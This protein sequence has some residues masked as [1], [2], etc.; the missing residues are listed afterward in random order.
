MVSLEARGSICMLDC[1]FRLLLAG[2]NGGFVCGGFVCGGCSVP[3]VSNCSSVALLV[4]SIVS[5][6]LSV[7]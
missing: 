3:F 1:S 4:G 7:P 2:G 6:V 5:I